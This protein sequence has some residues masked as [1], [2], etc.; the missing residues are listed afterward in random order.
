MYRVTSHKVRYSTLASSNFLRRRET[1]LVPGV[2]IFEKK[3]NFYTHDYLLLWLYIFYMP[4]YKLFSTAR[5]YL[6]GLINFLHHRIYSTVTISQC[7]SNF[8]FHKSIH[9]YF[10]GSHLHKYKSF[11]YLFSSCS[12]IKYNIIFTGMHC[13]Q[14]EAITLSYFIFY[15][16]IFE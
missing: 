3:V 5:S 13:E 11:F 16:I 14:H 2:T 8:I 6:L 7:I 1:R 12:F 10:L 9:L 4:P 15:F